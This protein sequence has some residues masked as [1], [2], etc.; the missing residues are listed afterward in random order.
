[1]VGRSYKVREKTLFPLICVNNALLSALVYCLE[2][3]SRRSHTVNSRVPRPAMKT[4]KAPEW[5]I[6]G[7]LYLLKFR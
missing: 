1:M 3:S 6:P 5:L 2:I 4:Q 7:P